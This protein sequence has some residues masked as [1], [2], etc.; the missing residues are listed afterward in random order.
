MSSKAM[1]DKKRIHHDYVAGDVERFLAAGG[2]IKRIEGQDTD[3]ESHDRIQKAKRNDFYKKK[4][5]AKAKARR[6][7]MISAAHQKL[8][9]G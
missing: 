6:L 3:L 8:S 9:N 5:E 7:A 2:S 4:A 1:L